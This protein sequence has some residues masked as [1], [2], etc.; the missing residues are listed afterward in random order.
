MVTEE[1]A[2]RYES[3]REKLRTMGVLTLGEWETFNHIFLQPNLRLQAEK[4]LTNRSGKE[5]IHPPQA[6]E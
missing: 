2:I 4:I 3:L 1:L 6:G 5:N